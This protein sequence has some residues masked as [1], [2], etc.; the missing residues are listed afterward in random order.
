MVLDDVQYLISEFLSSQA[1]RA[2]I[3]FHIFSVFVKKL[4]GFIPR[5]TI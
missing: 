3:K 1:S 4:G 2:S 5:E